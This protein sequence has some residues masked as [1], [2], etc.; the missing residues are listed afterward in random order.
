[1]LITLSPPQAPADATV[2][3]RVVASPAAVPVP[4]P[5]AAAAAAASPE[6]AASAEG[7]NEDTVMEEGDAQPVH[8]ASAEVQNMAGRSACH[9][10]TTRK[11]VEACTGATHRDMCC[12]IF[13]DPSPS[14]FI[15]ASTVVRY[16]L[17]MW[18][19]LMYVVC[20]SLSCGRQS[21]HAVK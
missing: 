8:L 19:D 1:M 13:N 11:S 9:Q 2:Q 18:L 7:E 5:A 15:S 16:T 4:L 12:G 3:I 6:V 14:F 17:I 10:N 21:L 20:H